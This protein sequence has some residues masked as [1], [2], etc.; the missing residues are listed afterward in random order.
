MAEE[1]DHKKHAAR[2][3]DQLELPDEMDPHVAEHLAELLGGDAPLIW[4]QAQGCTGCTVSLM[5]SVYFSPKRFG[6]NK[7]SLRYQ[8]TVMAAEGS[9]ATDIIEKTIAECAGRYIVVLEGAVPT[10]AGEEFCT[11]GLSERKTDLMGRK[12]PKD[13]TA[14]D[15]L[16]E[17][18]P[19]AEAV[20]AIGNCAAFGG[21]P[22]MESEVTGATAAT[23][24]VEAIDSGKPVI[25]VAGC[26]PH[27]DWI[28]GTL[29]DL[30]L[31]VGGHKQPPVLDDRG[32]LE[33]FYDGKVHD[34]CE[35][36]KAFEEKR[37]LEDWNDVAE[38][39]ERC[40]LKMGCRGP[41]TRG[42]CPTRLWNFH[43]NWCVGTN[44]PCQ[45]CTD[46]EF[47]RKLPHL[48]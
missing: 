29:V 4:I 45:G 25:N 3:A 36:R 27:P 35:R 5:N 12:V 30:L 40:L 6:G 18:V 2:I 15:W 19:G 10:G 23:D 1:V 28:M 22:V 21:I 47:Y 26:P 34:T 38:G 13:R 32:C 43:T 48:R 17:M 20:C 16:V 42:D 8:P 41:S 7:L 9:Q 31:W 24:V 33:Y 37:F 14:F 44:A 11:F 39:E 46:P